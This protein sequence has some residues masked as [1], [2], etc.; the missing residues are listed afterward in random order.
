MSISGSYGEIAGSAPAFELTY[1]GASPDS[2]VDVDVV[3]LDITYSAAASTSINPAAMLAL[4][5]I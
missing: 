5:G 2:F 1:G 4:L 3:Y